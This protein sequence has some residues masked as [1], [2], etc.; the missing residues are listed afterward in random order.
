MASST[1]NENRL[2]FSRGQ[3]YAKGER[4]S[5]AAVLTPDETATV[6]APC[7]AAQQ[8]RDGEGAGGYHITI[9][10]KEEITLMLARIAADQGMATPLTGDAGEAAI[11]ALIQARIDHHEWASLGLG[12][13]ANGGNRAY[14]RVVIWPCVARIR[15]EFGL[16]SRHLHITVGFAPSDVHDIDK[17]VNSIIKF[18]PTRVS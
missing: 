11:M 10:T 15:A 8:K 3:L 4:I 5:S 12:R 7:I 6:T 14:Y 16:P 2:R 13:A 18:D 9:A 1:T 17:G